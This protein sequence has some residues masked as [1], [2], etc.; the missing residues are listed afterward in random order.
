MARC[1]IY[2]LRWSPSDSRNRRADDAIPGL[3]PP[4][5]HSFRWV[6]RSSD[7]GERQSAAAQR[8]GGARHRRSPPRATRPRRR[9]F[10]SDLPLRSSSEAA[11]RARDSQ[12]P[13]SPTWETPSSASEPPATHPNRRASFST[14]PAKLG[15]CRRAGGV[16]VP[17]QPDGEA[18]S[19]GFRVAGAARHSKLGYNS[20]RRAHEELGEMWPWQKD[21]DH[22]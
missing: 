9:A 15:S 8:A 3:L 16:T 10:L 2:G 7:S 17:C 11:S 1:P 14:A 12:C 21:C 19:F 22:G 20:G 18:P 4:G 6:G 5:G 13:A